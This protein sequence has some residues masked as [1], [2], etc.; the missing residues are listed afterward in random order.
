MGTNL[1]TLEKDDWA[2]RKSWDGASSDELFSKLW[3][4]GS[5]E[6]PRCGDVHLVVPLEKLPQDVMR[7]MVYESAKPRDLEVTLGPTKS[8]PDTVLRSLRN[9]EFASFDGAENL[10]KSVYSMVRSRSQGSGCK[11]WSKLT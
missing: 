8:V 6:N 7:L 2:S 10:V 4:A 5:K 9:A 3:K 11:R 1:P